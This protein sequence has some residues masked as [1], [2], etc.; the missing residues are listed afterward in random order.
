MS[1]SNI[2]PQRQIPLAFD[3][4]ALSYDD[5]FTRSL[6]GRAQRNAVW[7]VLARVFTSDDRILELNCGTGEDA[8]FLARR[9]VSVFACDASEGMVEVARR[10]VISESL[11]DKVQVEHL[12]TERLGT[13]SQLSQFDGVLSN[14][15][16]LNCVADL[17]TIA[18]QLAQLVRPGAPIVLCLCTRFCL[19]EIIWFLLQGQPRKAFRRTSGRTVARLEGFD[20]QLQY[21]TVR[22]LRQVFS[23]DFKLRCCRGVGILVPPSYAESWAR[24]YPQ[25]FSRLESIDRLVCDLPGL[26]VIGDHFLIC[27]ERVA[28]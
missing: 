20:I 13:L 11:D 7:D 18:R 26:R 5:L 12:P 22:E 21:P 14:F 3:S 16:G 2:V 23:N 10:R 25:L 1:Q 8:V 27:F 17:A 28:S 6:V 15:S 9:G 4:L 24:R 19:F